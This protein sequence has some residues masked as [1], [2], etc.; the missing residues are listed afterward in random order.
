MEDKAKKI[1]MDKVHNTALEW[2]VAND[3]A[4]LLLT[5]D[6]QR[7]V[8]SLTTH[9]KS[10]YQATSLIGTLIQEPDFYNMIETALKAADEMKK[11]I[12]QK[13]PDKV[14]S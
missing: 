12:S 14:A 1:T 8:S 5:Y 7:G 2:C 6:S 10:D 13:N 9:G 3:G 11:K 4:I